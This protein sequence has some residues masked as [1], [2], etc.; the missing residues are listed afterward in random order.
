MSHH[1]VKGCQSTSISTGKLHFA[2]KVIFT[3]Y[4]HSNRH[5]SGDFFMGSCLEQAP[6]CS[7]ISREKGLVSMSVDYRLGPLHQFPAAVED[8]EDVLA[9]IL[10]VKGQTKAG[11]ALRKAILRRLDRTRRAQIS[12]QV[13]NTDRLSISGFSSGGNLAL[14]LVL[15]ITTPELDW[16][17]RLS[18]TGSKVPL[19]LGYPNFDS[20]VPP[21][22]RD[23]PPNMPD[24]NTDP[25]S[26][27]SMISK[28]L[29]PTYIK[30]HER[31]HLRA[32]PGLADIRTC[33]SPRVEIL[34]AL[35]EYDTLYKQSNEW[36]DRIKEAGREQC[37]HVERYKGIKHGFVQFPNSF[38]SGFER[39]EKSRFYDRVVQFLTDL[40]QAPALY[41]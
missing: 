35:P 2:G 19:I 14:N 17:S 11:L 3:E 21:H 4:Q 31:S 8:A 40:E 34:L 12:A 22:A 28:K 32:S 10:D 36:I 18:S 9:A 26:F 27:S 24:P 29:G 1:R 37:L 5:A 33:L 13:L 41:G 38:L 20:R 16:P 7:H 15:T 39:D 30:E 23:P 25:K 6:F